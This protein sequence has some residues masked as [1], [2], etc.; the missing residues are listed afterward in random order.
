MGGVIGLPG[1][2]GSERE[3]NAAP[4]RKNSLRHFEYQLSVIYSKRQ[5]RKKSNV[6]FSLFSTY[7]CIYLPLVVFI[8][9]E[10]KQYFKY[11][12]SKNNHYLS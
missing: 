10:H 2:C 6:T 11:T 9:N 5:R 3:G 12:R 8:I 1:S 4:P 7:L